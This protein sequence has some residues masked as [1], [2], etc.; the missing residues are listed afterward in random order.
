MLWFDAVVRNFHDISE[1]LAALVT[2]VVF[3]FGTSDES[4]RAFLR[5][6]P[7]RKRPAKTTQRVST[8]SYFGGFVN[9]VVKFFRQ[10]WIKRLFLL[11]AI[12]FCIGLLFDADN[13][14]LVTIIIFCL[15][16]IGRAPLLNLL[17]KESKEPDAQPKNFWSKI[18]E[19]RSL[20][21][22]GVVIAAAAF[23][24]LGLKFAYYKLFDDELIRIA[25]SKFETASPEDEMVAKKFHIS[26]SQYI[27]KNLTQEDI[28]FDAV[29]VNLDSTIR[30]RAEAE[31]LGKKHG[32]RVIVLW[33]LIAD[34]SYTPQFTFIN[35]PKGLVLSQTKQSEI[36]RDLDNI[37]GQALNLASNALSVAGFAIGLVQYW[38]KNYS[39]ALQLFE[40]AYEQ[41]PVNSS[42][43][44]YIG[45]CQYYLGLYDK[46][47]ATYQHMIAN[48]PE[49]VAPRNNLAVIQID[50]G[51]YAAALNILNEARA[52]D[53]KS[54]AV[55][56]NTGVVYNK[57][58]K[59]EEGQKYFT[60]ALR[61]EPNS[62]AALNNIAVSAERTG[63]YLT[64]L[65]LLEDAAKSE[66]APHEVFVNLGFV[67]YQHFKKYKEALRAFQKANNLSPAD[68][69]AA[70]GITLVYL[71]MGK[72]DE[73]EEWLEKVIKK[74]K[75]PAAYYQRFGDALNEV[76]AYEAALSF[77]QESLHADPSMISNYP[78]MA[79]CAHELKKEVDA[80]NYAMIYANNN[81][82]D[83]NAV[84]TF[85]LGCVAAFNLGK[86][87]TALE[88]CGRVYQLQPQN[89]EHRKNYAQTLLRLAITK[90]DSS[91]VPEFFSLIQGLALSDSELAE[92]RNQVGYLFLNINS[93]KQAIRQ[94]QK[95]LALFPENQMARH[96]L[97]VAY[98]RLA[99]AYIKQRDWQNAVN[100][101]DQAFAM[102]LENKEKAVIL[103]QKAYA[104][105][106]QGNT[107]ASRDQLRQFISYVEQHHLQN[108][109]EIFK[110]LDSAQKVLVSNNIGSPK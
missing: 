4:L 35:P 45:N 32:Q 70:L 10:K 36:I 14:L 101:Y 25:V 71:S 105:Q 92:Y 38:N 88:L 12:Y 82:S 81:P 97:I 93:Y 87:D 3:F 15:I 22:L 78:R 83:E 77:Y 62:P 100:T 52:L 17:Q 40:K 33:G 94:Y 21:E 42:I 29:L 31:N 34:K 109:A 108:D 74:S 26:L 27:Q 73:A 51:S 57:L 44:F 54:E 103:Y 75:S 60:A 39:S 91:K 41:D 46:A 65:R 2:L 7:T 58:G 90:S 95:S 107:D 86:L 106:Q 18:R 98:H 66:E 8:P 24:S 89:H 76:K 53:E 69:T 6:A 9:S 99:D 96:N 84:W 63:D 79:Q 85:E 5:K 49:A 16:L 64:A 30:S 50:R 28:L 47:A 13:P 56:V 72:A 1:V 110:Y 67:Y 37:Q 59:P 61:L 55:L 80:L 11:V 48:N 43:L 19:S 20:N 102:I 23:F 104:F 68:T